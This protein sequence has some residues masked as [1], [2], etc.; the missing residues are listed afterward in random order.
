MK[1]IQLTDD[2]GRV[3][4]S[5]IAEPNPGSVVLTSGEFGTA[6]QRLFSNGRW[7]S[8]TPGGA[9]S[10]TWQDLLTRRNLVLIYDAPVRG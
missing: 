5:E 9:L 6:W 4:C 8:T 3:V 7:S 1:I 2:H 10:V